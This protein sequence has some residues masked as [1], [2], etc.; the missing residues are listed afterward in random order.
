MHIKQTFTSATGLAVM[1][2]LAGC[3]GNV[4]TGVDV[5]SDGQTLKVPE[6][7]TEHFEYAP[8][9]V[10]FTSAKARP[11]QDL[12]PKG[13][14]VLTRGYT[15]MKPISIPPEGIVGCYTAGGS[16][17]VDPVLALIRRSDNQHQYTPYTDR[18]VIE[19]MAI[20]DDSFER[21][22]YISYSNTTGQTR[23]AFLMAFAYGNATGTVDLYCTGS[24]TETIQV[25]AGSVL[26]YGSSSTVTT[27]GGGDPWLFMLDNTP[28]WYNGV[29][30]DDTTSSN[31]E[32]TITNAVTG[33]LMWYVANGYNSGSTTVN[34]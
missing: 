20:N 7:T 9:D 14:V 24:D 27:S 3:S 12:S 2:F 23:N 17:G 25:A 26:T 11:I 19:T 5:A 34:Y 21:H 8:A 10:S 31:Y 22:P 29:W 30:N 16:V 32:S 13:S 1:T 6:K 33:T 18:V 4:D 28:G 15:F